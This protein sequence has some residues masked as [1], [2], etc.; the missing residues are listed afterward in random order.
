MTLI[1]GLDIGRVKDLTALVLVEKRPDRYVVRHCRAWRPDEDYLDLVPA[2]NGSGASAIAFDA[3]G[4][5]RKVEGLITTRAAIPVYPIACTMGKMPARQVRERGEV[6]FVPKATFARGSKRGALRPDCLVGCMVG[7]EL[8]HR[9]NYPPGEPGVKALIAERLN[10]EP[11]EDEDDGFLT[12][13]A[14]AGFHDDLVSALQL[15][16]WLGEN[17]HRFRPA[18]RRHA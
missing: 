7:L 10:Y 1:G 14:R 5:G 3:T 8:S 15:A 12:F 16:L 13:S 9:I 2:I 17:G 6:I 11:R 4:E 18:N